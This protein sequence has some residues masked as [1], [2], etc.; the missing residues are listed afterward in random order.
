MRTEVVNI[1]KMARKRIIIDFENVGLLSSSF[2]DEFIGKLI[3]EFGFFQYQLAFQLINLN[4]VNQG[5]LQRSV[6]QRLAEVFK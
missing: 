6:G 4:E 5:I 3:T 1:N 2:A